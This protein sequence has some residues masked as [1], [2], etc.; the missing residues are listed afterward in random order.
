M[1]ATI[2]VLQQNANVPYYR[3]IHVLP[4]II[5][6]SRSFLYIVA[7]LFLLPSR[8]LIAY[9]E[10]SGLEHGPCGRGR[11]AKVADF[12][13]EPAKVRGFLGAFFGGVPQERVCVE[14][15]LK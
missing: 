6:I 5:I 7:Q 13:G 4:E 2:G 10:E 15:C 11:A 9:P 1:Y 3:T 8:H 12:Y 14:T